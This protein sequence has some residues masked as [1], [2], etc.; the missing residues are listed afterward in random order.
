MRSTSYQPFDLY[1]DNQY[2]NVAGV[3]CYD[4][5]ERGWLYHF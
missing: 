4:G 3:E 5:N 1:P 2:S